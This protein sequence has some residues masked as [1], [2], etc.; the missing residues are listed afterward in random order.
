MESSTD[1]QILHDWIIRT[2]QDKYSRTYSEIRI[3]IGEER[4]CEF[5]GYYPDVLFVNYGQVTQIV[6]VETPE[7]VNAGR[8]K[9]WKELS[10]LGVKLVV[11]VPRKSQK[12]AMELCWTNSLAAKVKIG[13]YDFQIEM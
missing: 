12:H 4:G 7:S 5:K 1:E 13:T 11:L 8:V 6:E 10:E 9:Y 3:N 2:L